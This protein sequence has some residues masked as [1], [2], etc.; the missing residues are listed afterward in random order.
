[1]PHPSRSCILSCVHSCSALSPP[2]PSSSRLHL[3]GVLQ[4]RQCAHAAQPGAQPGGCWR[5][6]MTEQ[7]R[8]HGRHCTLCGCLVAARSGGTP[9]CPADCCTAHATP[10]TRRRRCWAG[11]PRWRMCSAPLRGAC[12]SPSHGRPSHRSPSRCGPLTGGRGSLA[13]VLFCNPSRLACCTPLRPLCPVLLCCWLPP[14]ALQT[15][16]TPAAAAPQVV[17]DTVELVLSAAEQS[18]APTPVMSASTLHPSDSEAA[19]SV[20]GEDEAAAAAGWA[21][22]CSPWR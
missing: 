4:P 14:E 16:P 20:G 11:Q 15:N 3:S 19:L 10:A 18:P 12:P 6:T 5:S 22:P 9:R 21:A 2:L 7:H 13:H 8:R 1:M 17:L